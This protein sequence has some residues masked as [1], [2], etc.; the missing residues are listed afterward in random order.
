MEHFKDIQHFFVLSLPDMP[1]DA[2]WVAAVILLVLGAVA[3][4]DLFKGIIPDA[5]MFFAVIGVV[6]AEGIYKDWPFSAHQLTWGIVAALIVWGINELWFRAFKHDALGM[7]DAK[8]SLLAVTCFGGLPVL[9]AWGVGAVLGCVWMG[10]L[11]IFRRSTAHVHFAPFLFVGLIIG[12]W[13]VR[14][15]GFDNVMERFRG[16]LG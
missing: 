5:P 1:P 9:F 4:V 10:V 2:W 14:I 13:A 16:G 3:I 12:I 15:A 7:G 11:K 6:A 8:W